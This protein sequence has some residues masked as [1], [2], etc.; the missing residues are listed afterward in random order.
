MIGT[1]KA[2]VK[3]GRQKFAIYATRPL[4]KKAKTTAEWLAYI[5]I[6]MWM[7]G[8]DLKDIGKYIDGIPQQIE[9]R[10]KK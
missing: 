3:S 1:L 4:P 6:D 8:Y 7:K 10:K 2:D 5:S 9:A